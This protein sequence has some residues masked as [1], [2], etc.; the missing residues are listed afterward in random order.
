MSAHRCVKC[1]ADKKPEIWSWYSWLPHP[2]EPEG[3]QYWVLCAPCEEEILKAAFQNSTEGE[4]MASKKDEE[5]LVCPVCFKQPAPQLAESIIVT[6]QQ[7]GESRATKTVFPCN[8][9]FR[10]RWMEI[11][12]H[13]L[14]SDIFF[15]LIEVSCVKCGRK[16]QTTR[17]ILGPHYCSIGCMEA[18]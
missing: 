6:I 9:C 1:R 14:P 5:K 15:Q 13:L 12:E 2:G 8:E 18:R 7:Q 16:S 4:T 11:Q 3:S 10:D 17:S